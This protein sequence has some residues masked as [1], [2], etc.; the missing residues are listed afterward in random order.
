MMKKVPLLFLI[1]GVALQTMVAQNTHR[2]N[3]S[4]D[5]PNLDQCSGT[6]AIVPDQG[7]EAFSLYPNP[8]TDILHIEGLEQVT[9]VRLTN[10]IGKVIFE[11]KGSALN[12]QLDM[13]AF[14]KG[15]YILQM[16][17]N[18]DK[19]YTRKIVKQ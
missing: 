14:G 12:G 4:I 17:G 10:T 16:T 11:G 2:I 19:T 15:V 7:R 13:S 6:T 8:V 1:T 9:S 3:V 5:Q 18:N